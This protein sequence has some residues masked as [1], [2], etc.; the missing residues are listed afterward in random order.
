MSKDQE[1]FDFGMDHY[2]KELDKDLSFVDIG[3]LAGDG[4]QKLPPTTEGKQTDIT[5]AQLA[6]IQEFGTVIMVS[7]KMRV[8][9]AATGLALSPETREITIPSRPFMRQTFDENESLLADLADSL[10]HQILTKRITVRH[11]LSE[12]GQ[13]HVNQI[14]INMSESGKFAANHPYTIARKKKSQPLINTGRLRQSI[15]YEV[16]L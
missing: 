9:L 11:A 8:F 15:N 10:E 14:Q 7:P 4:A 12:I 1:V 16:Q 13:T 3:I 6:T 2:L 5:L